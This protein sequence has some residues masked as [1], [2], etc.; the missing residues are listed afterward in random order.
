MKNLQRYGSWALV[1]G[2]SSGIGE[3]FARRIA[4]DGVNLVLAARR[5]DRLEALATELRT[6]NLVEV[7][8]VQVDLSADDGVDILD[9]AT[10]DIELGLIVSNAG[11][12]HPGSFLRTSVGEQLDVLRLNVATPMEIAHRLGGRL[13]ERGRGALILTGSTSAFAGTAQLA[14]YAATKAFVGTLAEGLHREWAGAGVDVMV[15][16]PG[17]TRTEMV[18]MPGVDFG[19][20]PVAWMD[21]EQVAAAAAAKIGRKAVLIPG[22]VNRLQTFVF[23]RLLPRSAASAIWSTLMGRVTDPSIQG[24]TATASSA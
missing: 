24:H 15:V 10:A 13:V 3:A 1:T 20:V 4:E 5:H 17:P 12:A 14:N 16:H 22:L 6:A 11:S 18:D 7:R 2:A 9:K 8:T 19:A 21:P 23:T